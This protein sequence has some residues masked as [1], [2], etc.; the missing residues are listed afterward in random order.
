[1]ANRSSKEGGQGWLSASSVGL[2][3]RA[4]R[5]ACHWAVVAR[6]SNP[7]LRVTALRRSS[8]EIVEADRP[9][10]SRRLLNQ[11]THSSVANSAARW[12]ATV[13]AD[14]GGLIDVGAIGRPRGGERGCQYV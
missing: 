10:S 13:C 14:G 5:S 1:M 6:Y 11:F 9:P 12:T 7:P 4:D 3:R 8:R 2:G